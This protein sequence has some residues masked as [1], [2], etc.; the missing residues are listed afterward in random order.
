MEGEQPPGRGV[1]GRTTQRRARAPL[2]PVRAALG[3]WC[4]WGQQVLLD[5]PRGHSRAVQAARFPRPGFLSL[6][7]CAEAPAPPFPTHGF[8]TEG[9]KPSSRAGNRPEARPALCRS[10]QSQ[11]CPRRLTESHPAAAWRVTSWVTSAHAHHL[12]VHHLSCE[13]LDPSGLHVFFFFPL[14]VETFSSSRHPVLTPD[15]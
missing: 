14:A 11:R 2:S 1:A 6:L 8:N 12:S 15:L 7:G 10:F 5:F 9:E 4:P 13:A 3:T